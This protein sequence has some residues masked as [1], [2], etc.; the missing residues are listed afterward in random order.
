MLLITAHLLLITHLL[1][2]ISGSQL[3]LKNN[4]LENSNAH[5]AYIYKMQLFGGSCASDS[6][7]L[8]IR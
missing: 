1:L 6:L 7:V 2:L 4:S 5:T 3:S 8:F